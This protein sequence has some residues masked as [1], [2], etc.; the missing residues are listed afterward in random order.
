MNLKV[1]KLRM[2]ETMQNEAFEFVVRPGCSNS[3]SRF[4]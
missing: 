2:I 3:A 1:K 4:C